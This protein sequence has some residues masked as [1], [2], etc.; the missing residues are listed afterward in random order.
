MLVGTAV[1]LFFGSAIVVGIMDSNERDDVQKKAASLSSINTLQ[2]MILAGLKKNKRPPLAC[3]Y[4]A[5]ISFR[6]AEARD[7]KIP[8]PFAIDL[9]ND[10]YLVEELARNG[11]NAKQVIGGIASQVYD[12]PLPPA[13]TFDVQLE[14]C[15]R[16][17]Q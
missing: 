11:F 15:T 1:V 14:A 7:L 2:N 5:A 3:W 10:Q 6:L 17:R 4:I 16:G 13:S 12:S 9:A 8:K